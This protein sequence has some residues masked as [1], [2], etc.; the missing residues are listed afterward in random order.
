MFSLVQIIL[1]FVLFVSGSAKNR[2]VVQ[3]TQVLTANKL[4]PRNQQ[5][6][7]ALESKLL[8]PLFKKTSNLFASFSVVILVLE[9]QLDR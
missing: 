3:V 1:P 9:K 4:S 6:Q 5:Q 2:D 7:T 8:R